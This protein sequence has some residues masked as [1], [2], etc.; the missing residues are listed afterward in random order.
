MPEKEEFNRLLD[1]YAD[2]RIS[3]EVFRLVA[4]DWIPEEKLDS[5][6][7]EFDEGRISKEEFIMWGLPPVPVAPP[8]VPL[9][10][11]VDFLDA[12]KVL[13]GTKRWEALSKSSKK[14]YKYFVEP[15][16]EYLM[17]KGIRK[18]SEITELDF[19]DFVHI[20]EKE[21]MEYLK[22]AGKKVEPY[23]DASVGHY[24]RVTKSFFSWMRKHYLRD[25]YRRLDLVGKLIPVHPFE[26]ME[27]P[28]SQGIPDIFEI[29]V[30]DGILV[31]S[32]VNIIW[33]ALYTHPGSVRDWKR[34]EIELRILR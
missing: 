27:C 28:V 2:G 23:S 9:E 18:V 19:D 30:E 20:R 32:E 16:L 34:F 29:Q 25:L 3:R 13:M 21:W 26:F 8:G 6:L 12:Y 1:S 11:E 7:K 14:S 33:N 22:K 31:E 5:L 4:K 10:P 24:C 17:K 15:F